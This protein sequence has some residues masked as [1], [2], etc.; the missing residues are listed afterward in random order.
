MKEERNWIIVDLET[1]KALYGI[2][3]VT[4]TFSTKEIAEEVAEQLFD[5]HSRYVILNRTDLG[6]NTSIKL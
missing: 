1:K 5:V 3:R 2:N 6:F 4:L